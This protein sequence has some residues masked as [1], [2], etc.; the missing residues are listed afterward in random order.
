MFVPGIGVV[1]SVVRSAVSALTAPRHPR[2][3]VVGAHVH[4]AVRGLRD[5]EGAA[6][7]EALERRLAA[8][9]SV[10]WAAVNTVLGFAV[11]ALDEDA[12]GGTGAVRAVRALTGAVEEVEEEHGLDGPLPEHPAAPDDIRR[13]ALALAVQ[14]AT[15]PLATVVRLSRLT[16]LPAGF[17]ALGT[18][19]DT[20][21]TL[22]RKAAAV[23]G[24][25]NTVLATT[26]LSALVQAGTG[27]F[28][29][30]AVD[31]ARH[32]LRLAE[33]A[34][35]REAWRRAAPRHTGSAEHVRTAAPPAVP[36][37]ATPLRDGPAERYARRAGW[38]AGTAFAGA[39]AVTGR[40]APSG[41]A[42]LA[43][44]PKPPWAAREAFAALLG[45]SLAVRGALVADAEALRRLD[46]VD[47]VVLDTDTMLTGRHLLTDL[48][49]LD[50]EHSTGDLAATVYRLFDARRPTAAH[51]AD[52]WRLAPLERLPEGG[53]EH[54]GDED[55]TETR[56][57]RPDRTGGKENGRTAGPGAAVARAADRLR[58]GGARHVL[59]LTRRGR[60]YAL[61]AV[62]PEVHETAES[63][64][65][66]GRRAGLTV[67]AA[68]AHTDHAALSDAHGVLPGGDRLAV[69]VRERQCDGGGVLLVSRDR[70]ALAAA[71]VGVGVAG[72][73]GVLPW[74][75]DLH[76]ADDLRHAL[77][78]VA[79]CG[80][81]RTTVRHGV[82]LARATAVVGVVTAVAAGRRQRSAA[83]S[84]LAVNAASA[85][86]MAE[87]VWSA[88][89]ALRATGAPVAARR[90]WHAMTPR[91]VLDLTD[92]SEDGLTEHQAGGRAGTA[93]A[94]ARKPSLLRAVA[95]ESANPLTPVLL[96]GAALSVGVGALLDAYIIVGVTFLSGCI[97]GVQR[98]LADR[99]VADLQRRSAVMATVVRDGEQ[100]RLPSER[101]VT[102]D[103]IALNAGDVVP[104]D[105]RLLTAQGL[106]ADESALTGESLPVAKD[107]A[108]VLAADVA[109]RTS[110][111]YEGTTVA[112][113][114]ARAVVVATG[115]A[116]E[117]GRGAAA[118]RGAPTRVGVERRLAQ[119]TRT[120][121]PVALGAAGTLMAVG[122]LRGRPARETVG[123]GVGLAV[124]SVPEGLPFLVS[125]A[126]LAAARRLSAQGVLVRDP[127][128][129]EAVGRTDVLC[130]DKTGT[131]TH[132]RMSL[133]AVSAEGRSAALERLGPEQQDVL[134]AALRA[135]PRR[136]RKQ[137]FAHVTDSVVVA[138]AE[139]AGVRRTRSARGWTRTAQLPFEPSRGFHA[140]VGRSGEEYVLS[141]KGAPE[142]V[143]QRCGRAAGRRL[144]RADR[145][146]LLAEGEKLAA[147]GHRV[148]AVAERR[149]PKDPAPGGKLTDGTVRKL[150]FLGFLALSD[151]VR[152]T[153]PESVRQL[154]DAGVHIVMITGD[155]PQTAEAVARQLGVVDGRRVVTGAE[156]D[157]MDDGALDRA[158][159]EIGVVARGTPVHKVRVVQAFQRLGRTVAMAG[160]GANDA[161]A[162][163]IADV[164]IA[165]GDRATPAAR[166]AADLVL[167]DDR[168]EAILAVL[169]EGR[170]MWA[171]VRQALAMLVGG[172]L[173]EI[174]FTVLGATVSGTSPL[175]A[176]QLLLVNLFT[177]LLPALALAVRPPDPRAAGRLLREG[178]EA[179]LGAALT[180]ETAQRAL[181]TSAGAAAGWL[182]A[183]RTGR[184]ARA[185]TVALAALVATQ[186]GQTLLI[187]GRDRSVVLSSLGSLLALAAVVQTPGLSH[188][189][190]CAPLGP[191][192]WALALTA[193]TAATLGSPLL[194]PLITRLQALVPRLRTGPA[195]G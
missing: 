140:A 77:V 176:R 138:G 177:D 166:A 108:P 188:F 103:V 32:A 113:G 126:Q 65:A 17:A 183:R 151:Q 101:L 84:L 59:A 24:P 3:H 9:P 39:F 42:A 174:A 90:P 21:P 74:G 51:E 34:A 144:D 75:A 49:P 131:L 139:E 76:V 130:F 152:S 129:I 54:G 72:P 50:G 145:E 190:D 194:L 69:S 41:G 122:L 195:T 123:A 118:G 2:A 7:A 97:G 58:Q 66:E 179:S 78:L 19:V 6:A 18:V 44:L 189:F 148:L 92:G 105:A 22:R 193:A 141:V 30:L 98:H 35:R 36:E 31:T 83:R 109:D 26:T 170:A 115:T 46:R 163:R 73:D 161:P 181:A 91:T 116:T 5:A 47:T 128:T 27:G 93:E 147:E 45:R 165:L 156:L 150:T 82:R 132:G 164:G 178:P 159:P 87:G 62:V 80:A 182:V 89:R 61:A 81:V 25:R 133:A 60:P 94:R 16:P 57:A 162:I 125:A 185:R 111:A 86:A 120:T 158:L 63:L 79:A 110:M 167:T 67:L 127:R 136:R 106:E 55:T 186:L 20:H 10:R 121:L 88:A 99:A 187:G 169:V 134:A 64:V 33:S 153:A 155:H 107:V 175:T 8:L 102:G 14:L 12:L 37:R 117:A 96:A 28:A 173:G 71:D 68:G 171:S 23:V 85:L 53:G 38:V 180:G 143:V 135:T 56:E 4:L 168:L 13:A 172:N 146:E 95:A 160:D 191:F 104:A 1:H 142:E 70:A 157:A 48:V 15:V 137:P 184:R 112:A 52:D 149:T 119:L 40:I 11:V 29:G 154:A 43:A 100:R 114:R 192:A 124:A